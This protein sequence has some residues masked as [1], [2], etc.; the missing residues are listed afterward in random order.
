VATAPLLAILAKLGERG[1]P[2]FEI[3]AR[4]DALADQLI[5]LRGQLGRL[6]N[7]RPEF[8]LI[9]EQALALIDHGDLD[10]ARAALNRGRE[11]ARALR[12]E[13]SR[14][15]AEFLAD[16]AR[17]DHLQLAYRR[18]AQKYAEAA[19]VVAPF[20]P[21]AEWQYV[22]RQASELNDQDRYYA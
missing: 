1:V 10:A 16:E 20:G 17:I 4:L 12:E 7:D 6:R 8:A 22:L 2:D 11:A 9:R 13:T 19:G 14:N 5:E 15:E 18:A 3:P 21:D